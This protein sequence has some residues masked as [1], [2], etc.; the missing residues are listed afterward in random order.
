MTGVDQ[1][2]SLSCQVYSAFFTRCLDHCRV[3]EE[4]HTAG[5]KGGPKFTVVEEIVEDVRDKK[6]MSGSFTTF[7]G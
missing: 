6:K 7:F 3:A 2:N 4:Q 5:N 1:L